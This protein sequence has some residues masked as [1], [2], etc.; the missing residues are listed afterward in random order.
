MGSLDQ[1]TRR[2][3]NGVKPFGFNHSNGS[4]HTRFPRDRQTKQLYK[5]NQSII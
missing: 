2:F 1:I 3:Y 5:I 4:W